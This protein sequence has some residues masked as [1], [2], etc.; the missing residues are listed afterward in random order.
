MWDKTSVAM[1]LPLLRKSA[2]SNNISDKRVTLELPWSIKRQS[3]F[4]DGNLDP[5][6]SMTEREGPVF[7][8]RVATWN[9]VFWLSKHISCCP[10]FSQG[11]HLRHATFLQDRRIFGSSNWSYIEMSNCKPQKDL[12]QQTFF[13]NSRVLD[14]WSILDEPWVV[15]QYLW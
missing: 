6:I 7:P 11:S 2:Y 5:L 10:S 4:W 8:S 12:I 13:W 9:L 3:W 1:E 15:L 14:S